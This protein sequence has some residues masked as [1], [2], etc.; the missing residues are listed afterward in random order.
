MREVA[1]RAHRARRRDLHDLAAA[2]RVQHPISAR[3]DFQFGGLSVH[4]ESNSPALLERLASYFQPFLRDWTPTPHEP[5]NGLVV[6][7]LETPTPHV[8]VDYRDWPRDPGKLHLKERIADL[9]GG[10]VVHKVRTGMH[11]LVGGSMRLAMGPCLANA[12]QVVNFIVTQYIENSL[13]RGWQL[14]HAAGVGVGAHG[15]A[16]AGLAGAGKSTLA[17]HLMGRGLAFVS[18]D[19]LLVHAGPEPAALAG[20][21]RVLQPG[22]ERVLQA[23]V[24]KL[25][26]INPG[27]AL[28]QPQLHAVLPAA[29]RQELQ[30]LDP[31]SLW[32]LE[33][34][35]D[36]DLDA[37]FGP[38]RLLQR[39]LLA[40]LVVLTWRRGTA[41]P[42]RVQQTSLTD[43]PELLAAIVKSPGPFHVDARGS[44]LAPL[45]PDAAAYLRHLARVP[46]FEISGGVDFERA[47]N[48][49]VELLQARATPV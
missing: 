23:G 21:D 16:L 17:L 44:A 27:T 28:H 43:R 45:T 32:T 13:H 37:A 18:N 7:A 46:V 41:S 22:P 29:R 4:V 19:R 6:T 11:F 12:N 24:P 1:L 5:R 20:V 14:C 49:C 3:G 33:E 38:G 48:I 9:P 31:N 2:V 25:P 34:K 36:V 47:A 40:G 39:T 30:Q 35:Y 10:R 15:L 26:R 42:P 8:D